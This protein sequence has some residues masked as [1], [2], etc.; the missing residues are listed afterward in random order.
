MHEVKNATYLKNYEILIVFDNQKVKIVDLYKA[1]D[2]FCGEI[3]KPL[4]NIDYFKTFK[5]SDGI[6]TLEWDNGAD[7][8]PDYLYEIGTS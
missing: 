1:L 8:S 3:F 2:G 5:I 7:I 6:A 4:K